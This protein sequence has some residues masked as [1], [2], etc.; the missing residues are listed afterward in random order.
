MAQAITEV[1]L[2]AAA[3]AAP[4]VLPGMGIAISA[5]LANSLISAGA[6]MALSGA[7][8]GLAA[9]TNN[10]GGLAVGTTTPIG[11]WGYIYGQQ[12]VGGVEIF[13]QSNSSQ[14]T[15]N[16]KELHR[17]YA[18][19]C[20]PSIADGGGG[21]TPF[22]LRIDGKQVLLNRAGAGCPISSVSH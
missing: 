22:Q 12:K 18:L 4:F 21:S 6:S 20:H 19:A 3:I 7:M 14:G 9:L 1:A 10:Q 16:N 5:T 17:V 11:P 2:G 8:S 13:R 15:S